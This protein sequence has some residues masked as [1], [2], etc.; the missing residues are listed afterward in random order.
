MPVQD[1][2]VHANA[3]I[4]GCPEPLE[5]Q[6]A[7]RVI[8]KLD[9][10]RPSGRM[11][12]IDALR[13]FDM[14][15]IIGTDD[16][17]RALAANSH[18]RF[19]QV[20]GNQFEHVA[21][22]GCHLYDLI[23]PVFLFIIGASI[24]FSLSKRMQRGDSKAS[25]YAHIFRRVAVLILL[26]MIINGNLLSWNIHRF[27]ASYSV[28]MVLALGYMVASLLLL[29]L[30]L[31]GQIIATLALLVGYWALMDYVPVPGHIVGV[32][33]P[34]R[35]L[36]DWLNNFALGRLQGPWH[37]GWILQSMTNGATAMLGVFAAHLL[38]SKIRQN[39]KLLWLIALG[40]TCLV[41]GGVWSFWFPIIKN[42]WTSTYVLWAGG[43]SYLAL[44][45]F[46]WIIDIR[47]FR[48]WAFPFV[49]VGMNAIVA[50]MA[51][52][53]FAR[54]FRMMA[55]RLVGGL[56]QYMGGWYDALGWFVA[57]SIL[58]LALYGLY[59]TRTFIRI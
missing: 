22:S 29:N 59:R 45:V 10:S 21:W 47:G 56:A 52:G 24:P 7:S 31:R 48:K 17:L 2:R 39:Q 57:M 30:G 27:T 37:N 32:Y 43:W 53:V 13:G 55:D 46:Y 5:E 18:H 41:A 6:R 50:Y 4:D 33:L 20:V 3:V 16:V 23:F 8:P 15:L 11:V 35:N 44:A 9:L 40:V 25:I 54:S 19:L 26:G 36:G 49:V 28:L 51:W 14:F 1:H 34:G 58:W 12:C 38:R 42:R